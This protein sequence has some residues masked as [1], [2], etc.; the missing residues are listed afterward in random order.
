MYEEGPY[1]QND[2]DCTARTPAVCDKANYLCAM[3]N[4]TT[5]TISTIHSST[6][7]FV[8]TGRRF[9]RP[10]CARIAGNEQFGKNSGLLL[11]IILGSSASIYS[12]YLQH[13]DIK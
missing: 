9:V 1:C 6:G 10:S 2:S 7:A 11:W 5:T 3:A 8:D 4:L 13:F 12:L